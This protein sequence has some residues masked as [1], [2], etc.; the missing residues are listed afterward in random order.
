MERIMTRLDAW[1]VLL[2]SKGGTLTLIKATLVAIPNDFLF[3]FTFPVS[4]ATM[5]EM[6]FKRFIWDDD[7]NHH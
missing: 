4:I 2:L 5:M 7:P 1:K 6:V 3:L